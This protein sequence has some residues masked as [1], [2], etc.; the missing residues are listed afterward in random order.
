MAEIEKVEFEF[1]DEKTEAED[2]VNVEAES[3]DEIEIVD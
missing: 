3:K 1:P 2:K